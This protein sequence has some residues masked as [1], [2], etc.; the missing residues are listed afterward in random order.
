M[1]IIKIEKDEVIEDSIKV[2][3]DGYPHAQPVFKR[4]ISAAELKT[5]LKAWKTNQ[6]KVDQENASKVPQVV[7]EID[8]KL[9]ALIDKSF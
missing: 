7:K 8:T 3:I 6:D 4:D 5:Q 1:K 2:F 9:Q